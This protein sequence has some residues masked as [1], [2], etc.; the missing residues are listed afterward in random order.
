MMPVFPWALAGAPYRYFCAPPVNN[1]PAQAGHDAWL[2]RKNSRE[3]MREPASHAPDRRATA[4][5]LRACQ[6][7]YWIEPHVCCRICA[8][9]ADGKF[10]ALFFWS[11]TSG[12]RRFSAAQA[13]RG[14]LEPVPGH[15][16]AFAHNDP[17]IKKR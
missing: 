14:F 11:T 10:R 7:T 5:G 13:R 9:R 15:N 4:T 8:Q 1:R 6:L 3:R 17:L 2:N 12:A 16:G